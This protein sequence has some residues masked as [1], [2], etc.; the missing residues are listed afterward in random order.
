MEVVMKNLNGNAEMVPILTGV[1]LAGVLLIVVAVAG[2]I[3]MLV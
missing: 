3:T 1:G 2:I